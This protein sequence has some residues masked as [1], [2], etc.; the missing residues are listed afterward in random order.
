MPVGTTTMKFGITRYGPVAPEATQFGKYDVL[1]TTGTPTRST[2]KVMSV[3]VS[4]MLLT[5][6]AGRRRAAG[7]ARI[8]MP[9]P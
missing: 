4:L 7:E 8:E 1:T 5:F 3:F 9:L 2:V 6:T